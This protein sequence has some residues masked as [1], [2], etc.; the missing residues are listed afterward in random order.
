MLWKTFANKVKPAT[1]SPHKSSST[2]SYSTITRNLINSKKHQ[3]DR[4]TGPFI[5]KD[6]G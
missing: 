5:T 3:L 6:M 1:I 2:N 4:N